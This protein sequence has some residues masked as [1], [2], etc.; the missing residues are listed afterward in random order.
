MDK[1]N[2]QSLQ[3]E[4]FEGMFLERHGN[5]MV[6]YVPMLLFSKKS[7]IMKIRKE[8]LFVFRTGTAQ[9]A[10]YAISLHCR[11]LLKARGHQPHSTHPL[12][13]APT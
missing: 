3:R 13:L 1:N 9:P 2:P 11:C 6:N 4:G 7:C 5:R 8:K 12:A 10:T